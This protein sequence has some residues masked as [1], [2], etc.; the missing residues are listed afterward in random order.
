MDIFTHKKLKYKFISIVRLPNGDESIY[1]SIK[2]ISF[3]SKW[4]GKLNC[5]LKSSNN[6]MLNNRELE[7]FDKIMLKVGKTIYPIEFEMSN[8][9]N[10][11]RMTNYND[12][13]HRWKIC[14]SSIISEYSNAEL[15]TK[16]IDVCGANIQSEDLLLNSI[17]QDLFIQ[18]FFLD[19]FNS[20]VQVVI[21]NFPKGEE[22]HELQFHKDNECKNEY[23]FS[24]K[25]YYDDI[26]SIAE[27]QCRYS[28]DGIPTYISLV[29][30]IDNKKEGTFTKRVLIDLIN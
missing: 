16:Y 21:Y 12:V 1:S 10:F 7:Y 13:V 6:E 30:T 19:R 25:Y 23:L 2:K 15:L 3:S 27:L 26:N 9:G 11:Y 20:S 8:R 29:Y 24:T 5:V 17:K 22:R 4:N 28:N 18:L 14:T